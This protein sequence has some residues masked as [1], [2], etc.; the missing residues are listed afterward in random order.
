[1]SSLHLINRPQ[2][3]ADCLAVCTDADAILLLQDGVYALLKGQTGRAKV[4][5]LQEDIEARGLSAKVDAEQCE[6][7]DYS[8]FVALCCEHRNSVNWG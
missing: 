2:G 3:L 5:A 1:M 8:G 6:L 4:Y 7:V